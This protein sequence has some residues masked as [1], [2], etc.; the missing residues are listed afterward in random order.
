ML[1]FRNAFNAAQYTL[2]LGA[3][4]A[5]LAA[6]GAHPA[7]ASP[8]VPA[9]SRVIQ[10][11]IA[12]AAFFVCNIVLVAVAVALHTRAPVVRTIR[13]DLPYQVLV[14]VALLSVAPLVVVVMHR[15]AALVPLFLVPLI[16]VY[17]N[18]SISMNRAHQALHDELTGLP[19][20]KYLVLRTEEALAEA[21]RLG[22]STA[23]LLLDLDRFKEVNDT[24]GHPVGDRL[25]A[26]V[27]HRLAHSVRPGDVVARLGGDE[28]AVLLPAVRDPASAREVAARLRA[29]LA[30]PVRMDSMTLDIEASVGIAMYPVHAP[31]FALLLQRADVAMYQA[32]E[33][34]SGVEAYVAEQDR[35]S[36]ARLNLVGELRRA[37]NE[38]Q[39]E[40]LLPAEDRARRRPACG[41]GGA[42]QVAP[43]GPWGVDA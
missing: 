13:A 3:A 1:R 34:R 37:V 8:W 5:V 14:S 22:A 4:A 20:R 30:E 2:S 33:R 43:S 29:A 9:G 25:L 19:N 11:V 18:A 28:F 24:L 21:A 27:A 26:V 10:V 32:K 12:V 7:P 31:D 17:T 6:A 35:N 40:L 16:A 15:S 23:L 42:R 36:P 38:G 39:F 41:H